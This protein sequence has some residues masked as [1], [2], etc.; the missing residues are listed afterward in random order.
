MKIEARKFKEFLSDK[1]TT[2][3]FH[4]PASSHMGGMWERGIKTVKDVLYSM[5][6]GTVLTEFQL[7]TIFTEIEAIVNNRPLTHV[8]D[9]PDDFE[10]LTP[11]HFLLGRFNA[12]GE[13]CQDADGD[14]SSRYLC[15]YAYVC[16]I[17]IWRD[18]ALYRYIV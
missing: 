1:G 8:I 15:V 7:R 14:E 5:R 17:W 6:K 11:K 13:V 9:S 16:F 10:A 3:N 18:I 12:T 2:W 4:P